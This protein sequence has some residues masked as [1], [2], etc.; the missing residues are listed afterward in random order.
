MLAILPA[1][2]DWDYIKNLTGDSNW[3]AQKMRNYYK[4]LEN[5]QYILPNDPTAHGV[6]G[7]L[8]TQLTPIIL[9]AQDLKIIS[10]VVAAA[11][12]IGINTDDLVGK[13]SDLLDGLLGAI[14]PGSP[15]LLGL[16][17]GLGKVS[18]LTHGINSHFFC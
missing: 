18:I 3:D 12:T 10:L 14:L 1:N 2:N 5:N 17:E 11:S 13:V 9:V 16:V 6:G 8:S 15:S 4:K 7:W